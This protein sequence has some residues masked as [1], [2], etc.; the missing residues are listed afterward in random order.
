MVPDLSFKVWKVQQYCYFWIAS[1]TVTA[2]QV[3]TALGMQPDKV[4]VRG[5]RSTAP[6]VIP[7]EHSWKIVCDQ[8][9][10][11]DEQITAVLS[12]MEPVSHLVRQL[13]DRGDVSA[14]VMMVRHFDD[15]D[16]G[17]N[18]MGWGLEPDQLAL[19]AAMGADLQADEYLD[20]AHPSE[21]IDS[22]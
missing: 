22:P 13:V 7:I 10:R 1:E 15:E 2:E 5:S 21:Y 6:R 11:I 9:G 19:L 12:R 14:G 18:A 20:N 3:S 17:Y 8:H 4:T 16:G